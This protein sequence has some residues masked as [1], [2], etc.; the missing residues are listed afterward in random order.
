MRPAQPSSAP[1]PAR[2]DW[3]GPGIVAAAGLSVA[4][5]F[6]Q[7]AATATLGDVAAAFGE[8]ATGDSLVAQAGLAGSTLGIGLAVVRLASLASLPLAE[9]ADRRGRRGVLLGVA[10]AGL[11]FRTVYALAVIPLLGVPLLARAL[12]E[13]ERY[14]RLRTQ[15][16][17]GPR[18]RLSALGHV[19]RALRPTLLLLATLT[20]A[21]A[22]VS[23][24]VNSLLF[25]YAERIVGLSSSVTAVVV[26]AAGPVG[27]AGLL[28]GRWAADRWGRRLTAGV[29]QAVVA[30][31]GVATYRGGGAFT[32]AGYLLSIC[33][34]GA[35]GPAAAAL[36]AELFPTSMR[37]T[38]A[39]WLTVSGV[40]GAVSGLVAFGVLADAAGFALAALAV[41]V[42]V[43]LITPLYARLPETRG[44]ELEQSAPEPEAEDGREPPPERG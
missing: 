22:F 26:V 33:A 14:T 16:T 36:A 3:L 17:H 34:S 28:A 10:A 31:A 5:G 42:P 40:L 39:G 11:G 7:F 15:L 6:A 4:S 44:L 2:R 27:L 25:L 9:L 24:P 29:S 12:P 8:T 13:P 43:A 20:A 21:L 1:R 32:I 41:G 37:A 38:A 30:L 18:P 35:F 19:P 23:G